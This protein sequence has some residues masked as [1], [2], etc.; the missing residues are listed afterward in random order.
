MAEIDSALR[1]PDDAS[2]STASSSRPPTAT[3]QSIW[4]EIFMTREDIRAKFRRHRRGHVPQVPLPL[5]ADVPGVP[6]G[7]AG[8]RCKAWA[9]PDPRNIK[10]WKR[11]LL[12]DHGHAPRELLGDLLNKTAWEDY[13]YG[14]DPGVRTAWCTSAVDGGERV[15]VNRRLGDTLKMIQWQLRMT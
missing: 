3:R 13:G 7:E 2:G 15:G 8:V 14:K 11:P 9:G 4:K 12:P 5:L 1:L 10:S 6:P